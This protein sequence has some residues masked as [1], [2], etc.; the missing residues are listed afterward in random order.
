[1]LSLDAE[2]EVLAELDGFDRLLLS[3]V[4]GRR[5]EYRKTARLLRRRRDGS[6]LSEHE[7]GHEQRESGNSKGDFAHRKAPPDWFRRR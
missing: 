6:D 3:R 1:V 5:G 7:P 2:H 4:S